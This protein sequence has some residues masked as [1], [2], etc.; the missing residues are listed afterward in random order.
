[1]VKHQNA[2]RIELGYGGGSIDM[3]FD[4]SSNNIIP[5]KGSK[6]FGRTDLPA[7][8]DD[9]HSRFGGKQYYQSQSGAS[10]AGWIPAKPTLKKLYG[11]RI[12]V[13]SPWI[14]FSKDKEFAPN[15]GAYEVYVPFSYRT[16]DTSGWPVVLRDR[17]DAIT[18]CCEED[19]G[20]FLCGQIEATPRVFKTTYHKNTLSG[21][22]EHSATVNV[23][24]GYNGGRF[25]NARRLI[26]HLNMAT[27]G[28]SN[29]EDVKPEGDEQF[30]KR[31]GLYRFPNGLFK[32]TRGVCRY[33]T[34][35]W[36]LELMCEF[37]PS[38]VHALAPNLYIQER[39]G[40][41]VGVGRF[42]IDSAWYDFEVN[43]SPE[44]SFQIFRGARDVIAALARQLEEGARNK[45]LRERADRARMK[46]FAHQQEEREKIFRALCEQFADVEVTVADSLAAGNCVPGTEDFRSR[47]FPEKKSATVKQ[48]SRFLSVHGVRRVLE[49]ILLPRAEASIP[50]YVAPLRVIY[51][52]LDTPR[53]EPDDLKMIAGIN[54]RIEQRLNDAGVFHFWQIAALDVEQA[55]ALDSQIRASGRVVGDA[56]VEQA[57]KLIGL[58][59]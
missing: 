53:G 1:M 46:L 28:W 40:A 21:V 29:P 18:F 3:L 9:F 23:V 55:S 16:G 7:D 22:K 58:V 59:Q 4:I 6:N 20:R 12:D 44:V 47:E 34:E 51:P 11:Y 39:D 27:I 43:L 2:S 30:W 35:A 32:I 14:A 31:L 54:E 33:K 15:V 56:W 37:V 24:E 49:H 13:G 50:E 42:E 45:E 48:L 41:Y 19:L 10:G 52:G 17:Y 5:Y 38:N 36:N 57:R 25:A 26:E 8:P